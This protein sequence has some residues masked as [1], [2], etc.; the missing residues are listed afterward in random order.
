MLSRFYLVLRMS[1]HL[2]VHLSVAGQGEGQAED[3][4]GSVSEEGGRDEDKT[5]LAGGDSA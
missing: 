1:V 3:S 4:G 5:Q 2:S